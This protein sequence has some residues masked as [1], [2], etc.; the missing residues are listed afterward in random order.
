MKNPRIIATSIIL[1]VFA[2][3]ATAYLTGC[4]AAQKAQ[5]RSGAKAFLGLAEETAVQFT[6]AEILQA[7]YDT[8]DTAHP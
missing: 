1:A 8:Q 6:E 4:S 3:I 7:A 5:F 2:A